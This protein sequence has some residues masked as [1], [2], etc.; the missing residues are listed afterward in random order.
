MSNRVPLIEGVGMK[1]QIVISLFVVVFFAI[2]G[3]SG[4]GG[5]GDSGGGSGGTSFQEGQAPE[6]VSGSFSVTSTIENNSCGGDVH[7]TSMKIVITQNGSSV[8]II[9]QYGN[10]QGSGVVSGNSF[11]VEVSDSASYEGCN[12]AMTGTM[13]GTISGDSLSGTVVVSLN[14]EGSCEE[15]SDC[16]VSGTIS[17]NRIEDVTIPEDDET[18]TVEAPESS[19]LVQPSQ[20]T[21]ATG[22][23]KKQLWFME[24]KG[25]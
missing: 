15:L 9:D 16:T 17:G 12:M 8:S 10:D 14:V 1:K 18:I 21:I 11:K 25:E 6:D 23:R 4:D 2:V 20:K 24:I 22:V 7:G 13:I 19:G 3:C 5:S